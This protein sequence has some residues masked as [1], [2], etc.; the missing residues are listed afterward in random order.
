M[1]VELWALVITAFPFFFASALAH[2]QTATS[3]LINI[4]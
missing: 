2:P 4:K 3:E 1:L